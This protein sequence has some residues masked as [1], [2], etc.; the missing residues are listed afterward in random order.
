MRW[1]GIQ[2]WRGAVDWP[3]FDGGDAMVVAGN[4]A[5]KLVLCLIA[6]GTAPDRRLTNW[7]ACA[8]TADGATPP[9]GREHWSRPGRLGA[10]R[11]SARRLA[12][13]PFVNVATMIAETTEIFECP[14]CDRDPLS[15]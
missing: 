12:E 2:M 5:A 1:N 10:F 6:P 15:W 11:H 13:L 14:M 9:P 7:V 3:A 8:R 4:A